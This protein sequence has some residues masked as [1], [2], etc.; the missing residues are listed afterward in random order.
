VR[1]GNARIIS[2]TRIFVKIID[3]YQLSPILLLSTML[4]SDQHKKEKVL[5]ALDLIRKNPGIKATEAAYITHVLY[6]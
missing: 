5:V 2:N 6:Y 1:D 4:P 3:S